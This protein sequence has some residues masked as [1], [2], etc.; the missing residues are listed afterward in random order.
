MRAIEEMLG[1]IALGLWTKTF[2]RDGGLYSDVAFNNEFNNRDVCE[3]DVDIVDDG[4]FGVDVEGE[5]INGT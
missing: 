5:P 4:R 3:I 1:E 2:D